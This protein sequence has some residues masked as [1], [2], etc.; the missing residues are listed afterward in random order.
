MTPPDPTSSPTH[1][2]HE[3][4]I[5]FDQHAQ[6]IYGPQ[7]NIAGGLHLT[8]LDPADRRN[9]RNHAVLRQAVRRFW[10]EG[11]L[12]SS[13]YNAVLIRLGLDARLDAVDN[14]PWDLILQQ[15]GQPDRPITDDKSLVEIFDDL[16]QQLL[17]LGEPGSGKT[18][19]LLALAEALLNRTAADPTLPTP[20]VFNLF[21]LG[22]KTAPTGRLAG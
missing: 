13:L 3:P 7:I 8:R 19:T 14:R 20:V 16:D 5:T 9:Q 2:D 15:P 1:A 22:R 18:T 10:I 12:H 17:I 6:I 4:S 21:L 11:V